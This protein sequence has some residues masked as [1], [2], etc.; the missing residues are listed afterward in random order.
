MELHH[1]T[2]SVIIGTIGAALGGAIAAKR[3]ADHAGLEAD[4]PSPMKKMCPAQ[5]E[6]VLNDT[7]IKEAASSDSPDAFPAQTPVSIGGGGGGGENERIVAN[8]ASGTPEIQ[9]VDTPMKP[10]HDTLVKITTGPL[11]KRMNDSAQQKESTD[12]EESSEESSEEG[13]GEDAV[14]Q[15]P[16]KKFVEA[17]A[18]ASTPEGM[19]QEERQEE[20]E[21]AAATGTRISDQRRTKRQSIPRVLENFDPNNLLGSNAHKRRGYKLPPLEQDGEQ[22]LEEKAEEENDEMEAEEHEAEAKEVNEQALETAHR[23]ETD[24]MCDKVI[25]QKKVEPKD[26]ATKDIATNAKAA[27]APTEEKPDSEPLTLFLAMTYDDVLGSAL[28]GTIKGDAEDEVR[29]ILK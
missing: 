7:P 4:T 19:D 27:Y 11:A 20:E 17:S 24:K 21:E 1:D 16:P 8:E 9:I 13:N 6:G 18:D 22:S 12:E 3:M 5:I 28:D 26:I 10:N 29:P 15:T 23:G 2:V 14:P 25:L